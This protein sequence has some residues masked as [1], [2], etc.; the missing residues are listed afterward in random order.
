MPG[1]DFIPHN[2]S[3]NFIVYTGTH[4]NNTTLG[5]FREDTDE[6]MRSRLEDYVGHPLNENNI[7]EAM[8]RLAFG[9]VAKTAILPVQDVLNLDEKSKMNSPGSGENNWVWRL[10]PN[11]LTRQAEK[12]LKHWTVLYN[13]N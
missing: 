11:Q 7:C 12:K 4:D 5:W 6:G 8:A 3:K 13:R 9:S 1:S 2:Y 10:F